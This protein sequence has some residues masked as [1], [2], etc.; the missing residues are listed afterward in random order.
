MTHKFIPNTLAKANVD[1]PFIILQLEYGDMV[2]YIRPDI[3]DNQITISE[4]EFIT[5]IKDNWPITF[6]EKFEDTFNQFKTIVLNA[7]GSWYEQEF[8]KDQFSMNEII[9]FNKDKE[10]KERLESMPVVDR[11]RINL[12]DKFQKEKQKRIDKLGL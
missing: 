4:K 1:Y 5:F 2:T 10:E 7:D 9:K 6:L 11:V 3:E 8:D 12:D